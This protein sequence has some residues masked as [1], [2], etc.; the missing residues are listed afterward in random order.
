MAAASKGYK[1]IVEL[2]LKYNADLNLKDKKN[3]TA[4]S[5]AEGDTKQLLIGAGG[6]F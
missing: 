2:L 3:N 1:E 6:T 4:L 5:Y